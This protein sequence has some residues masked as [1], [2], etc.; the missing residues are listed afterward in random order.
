MATHKER[1]AVAEIK[2]EFHKEFVQDIVKDVK[3]IKTWGLGLAFANLG[4]VSVPEL[5]PKATEAL[6]ASATYL[7]HILSLIHIFNPFS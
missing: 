5:L 3:Q 1:L 4:V 7:P 2:L 6:N